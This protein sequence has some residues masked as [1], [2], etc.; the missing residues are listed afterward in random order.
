MQLHSSTTCYMI[1]TTVNWL[2]ETRQAD[3]FKCLWQFCPLLFVLFPPVF[4]PPAETTARQPSALRVTAAAR[5]FHTVG[6][7]CSFPWRRHQTAQSVATPPRAVSAH[8]LSSLP[9][10]R[11]PPRTKSATMMTCNCSRA[12]CRTGNLLPWQQ[13]AGG[14]PPWRGWR[15]GRGGGYCG[16]CIGWGKGSGGRSLWCTPHTACSVSYSPAQTTHSMDRTCEG[17][18]CSPPG[19]RYRRTEDLH[20][21]SPVSLGPE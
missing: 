7:R 5:S 6:S 14:Q 2:L 18:R 1:L 21:L 11:T 4:D 16:R 12:S 20:L 10:P 8:S 13:K 15:W 3:H 17:S 19:Q 9:Q